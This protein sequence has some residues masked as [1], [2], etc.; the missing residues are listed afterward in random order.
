MQSEEVFVFPFLVYLSTYI[1]TGV[2]YQFEI[3]KERDG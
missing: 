3:G 1:E 2:K